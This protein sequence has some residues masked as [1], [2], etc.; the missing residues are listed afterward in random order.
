MVSGRNQAHN[1][2]YE[3]NKP[4]DVD[5]SDAKLV[6]RHPASNRKTMPKPAPQHR[7]SDPEIPFVL[8]KN[9]SRNV[10]VHLEQDK[11]SLAELGPVYLVTEAAGL[12]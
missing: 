5:E 11:K 3:L 2:R 7:I 12:S 1:R 8:S 9:S 6:P 4:S 10:V